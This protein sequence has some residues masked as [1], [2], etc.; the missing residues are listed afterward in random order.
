M[1]ATTRATI[2]QATATTATPAMAPPRKTTA[3]T[4]TTNTTTTITTTHAHFRA[5]AFNQTTDLVFD[6]LAYQHPPSRGNPLWPDAG[7]DEVGM[8][9]ANPHPMPAFDAAALALTSAVS[10]GLQPL[11]AT[12][13]VVCHIL[14]P[15]R[16]CL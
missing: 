12:H 1:L 3:T 16:A 15:V 10:I 13:V 14:S 5:D 11:L 7:G 9:Q 6:A 4:T 8:Q 2:T